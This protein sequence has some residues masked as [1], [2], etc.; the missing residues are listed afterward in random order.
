MK[1]EFIKAQSRSHTH[2]QFT[3]ANVKPK[4][5]KQYVLQM[6]KYELNKKPRKTKLNGK[7]PYLQQS[8]L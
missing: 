6:L 7:K 5:T 8:T 3:K 2:L 4:I 1:I